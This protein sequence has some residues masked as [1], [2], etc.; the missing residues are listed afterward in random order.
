MELV[1]VAKTWVGVPVKPVGSYRH[2][3]NCL[4]LLVGIVRE[5]GGFEDMISDLEKNIGFK[6]PINSHDLLHKMSSNKH[7]RSIRPIIKRP[8]NI[9][10]F[11]TLAGPQHI[12]IVTEPGIVLHSSQTKKKVIEHRIPSGWRVALECEF[13]GIDD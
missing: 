8:G 5:L 10:L 13:L 9:L 12:G 3:V 2:G 1:K 6:A 11:F 7:L 4:G